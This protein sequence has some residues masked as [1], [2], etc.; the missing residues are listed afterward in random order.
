M[1][2]QTKSAHHAN[3]PYAKINNEQLKEVHEMVKSDLEEAKHQLQLIEDEMKVRQ[4]HRAI[5]VS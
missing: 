4:I 5:R 3:N 1:A 2:N